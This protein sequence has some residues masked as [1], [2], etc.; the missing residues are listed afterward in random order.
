MKCV[1]GDWK[2]RGTHLDEV[3]KENVYV[4]KD[5]KYEEL[6]DGYS[7]LENILLKRKDF[8]DGLGIDGFI[9][10]DQKLKKIL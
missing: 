4:A 3:G 2:R 7:Y 1:G 10:A 8:L 6:E 5:M 9:T